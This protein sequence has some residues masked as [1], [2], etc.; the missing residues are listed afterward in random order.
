MQSGLFGITELHT[1]IGRGTRP[2][3]LHRS[4]SPVSNEELL[5]KLEKYKDSARPRGKGATANELGNN[6]ARVLVDALSTPEL[7]QVK[8]ASFLL[9]VKG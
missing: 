8:I 6:Y 2:D 3:Y 5:E 1:G 9:R 4:V 7:I